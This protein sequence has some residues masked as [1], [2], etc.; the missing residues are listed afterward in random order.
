MRE[1]QERTQKDVRMEL[2]IVGHNDWREA[3]PETITYRD[4][5]VVD[6]DTYVKD[7]VRNNLNMTPENVIISYF[8][9]YGFILEEAIIETVNSPSQG[10]MIWVKDDP[11][12]EKPP[13]D[14]FEEK[15]ANNGLM[16]FYRAKFRLEDGKLVDHCMFSI[17]GAGYL[18]KAFIYHKVVFNPPE[19]Y[20]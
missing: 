19:K 7:C 20:R 13:E 5:K 14:E 2:Q 16:P 11:D 4:K 15:F 1:K 12:Y 17:G 18:H 10:K 8:V 6:F 9:R 3:V